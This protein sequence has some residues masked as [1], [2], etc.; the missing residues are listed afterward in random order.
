VAISVCPTL[1]LSHGD[2]VGVVAVW[3]LRVGGPESFRS[4]LSAGRALY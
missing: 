2:V 4:D 3:V 1:Q